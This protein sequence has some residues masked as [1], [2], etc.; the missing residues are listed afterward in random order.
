MNVIRG[1]AQGVNRLMGGR[2]HYAAAIAIFS[3]GVT[4]I[5]GVV[6]VQ[7]GPGKTS[8][9]VF[10]WICLCYGVLLFI[11]SVVVSLRGPMVT[12]REQKAASEA[13][14][15]II[16]ELE[17]DL[18]KVTEAKQTNQLWS[19]WNPLSFRAWKAEGY[20]I[21]SLAPGIFEQVATAYDYLKELNMRTIPVRAHLL[22]AD[23]VLNDLGNAIQKINAGLNALST[24]RNRQPD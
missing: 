4:L 8:G 3:L 19:Y 21:K 14:E 10:G 2:Q 9:S 1:L 13:A 5:L 17:A 18:Q 15:K 6:A 23:H 24:L 12:S 16:K 7:K 11:L 20:V 22:K